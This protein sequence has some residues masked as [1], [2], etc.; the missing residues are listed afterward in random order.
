LTPFFPAYFLLLASVS[1]IGKNIG[2]LASSATRAA[3]HK[4]FTKFDH[5]G[6]ITAKA[7]AQG[8]AAGLLG[9]GLGVGLSY[10]ISSSTASASAI[11]PTTLFFV[12]AP[13][14]LINLGAS[15]LANLS[16]VTRSLN[17][18]RSEWALSPLAQKLASSDSFPKHQQKT[19]LSS[20]LP[21]PLQVSQ[22]ESIVYQKSPFTIPL[23]LE[24][25]LLQTLAQTPLSQS[26]VHQFLSGY[27]AAKDGQE[28]KD[29]YR[30]L[31]INQGGKRKTSVV[32]LWFVEGAQHAH[33][34]Q[35]MFHASLIRLH[36]SSPSSVTS[37]L[38]SDE[39]I[40][41]T[42]EKMKSLKEQGNKD[43]VELLVEKGWELESCHIGSRQARIRLSPPT[44]GPTK[45]M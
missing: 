32:A 27:A 43:V 13:L 8:T 14:S 37:I 28:E 30:L 19:S 16:V 7:G 1:N 17:V 29:F 23:L 5:L 45:V 21:T 26:Q 42:Y 34:I 15:Y 20:L 3:M 2:W 22:L 36:L 11:D 25:P 24:P 6:D 31:I 10:L 35:G 4:S 39:L 9:T 12:F 44:D 38:P 41:T 18:E 40:Q 33:M